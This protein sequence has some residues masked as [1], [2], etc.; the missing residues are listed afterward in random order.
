MGESG[1]TRQAASPR[2]AE[3]LHSLDALRGVALLLGLVVHSTMPYIE[4]P[5]L[6]AVGRQTA[7]GPL[8]WLWYYLHSFR[9]AVFFLMAGY[10]GAMVVAKRGLAAWTRDRARRVLLVF[11]V[12]VVP[13]K[14]ALTYLAFWGGR[15][16][17]WLVPTG[18]DASVWSLTVHEL[19]RARF[20]GVPITHLWFLYY[21]CIISGCWALASVLALRSDR[22]VALTDAGR[23]RLRHLLAGRLAPVWLALAATPALSRMHSLAIDTPDASLAWHVP[24]LAVYGM[25]FAVGWVMRDVPELLVAFA[26]RAVGYVWIGLLL[27]LVGASLLAVRR[28]GEP[29]AQTYA[30]ELRWASSLVTSAV[31][32]FSVLG[33]V[34]T[35][36]RYLSR[37]NRALR[38]LADAS[39]W[40]YVM[41]LPVMIALQV[42]WA[43]SGLPWVVQVPL[44][45][46]ATF[47]TCVASY[48]LLVR[49]TWVG[50]WLNGSRR[51]RRVRATGIEV[52]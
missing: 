33:W 45:N 6:W 3:R 17:G 25:Y 48:Q 10:F 4:L 24:V 32:A 15:R 2:A 23:R 36:V 8:A 35:F 1:G 44:V 47:A 50:A 38:Y 27:S 12:A 18:R 9:L 49:S 21:L 7:V 30:V 16:T 19:T 39:Y 43:G 14:L 20:P 5:G 40:I 31:A 28:V 37:P 11:V 51:Q 52:A 22:L 46:L 42:W 34:G 41:H 29:W 26:K 13:M